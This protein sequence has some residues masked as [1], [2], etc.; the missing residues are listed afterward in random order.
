MAR[1]EAKQATKQLDKTTLMLSAWYANR[2]SDSVRVQNKR[3]SELNLASQALH[4]L[5]YEVQPEHVLQLTVGDEPAKGSRFTRLPYDFY[6][7][8]PVTLDPGEELIFE[9]ADYYT[10]RGGQELFVGDY[11]LWIAVSS[12]AEA[13]HEH[14]RLMIIEHQETGE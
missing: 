1:I 4:S 11:S 9:R 8:Y 6:N 7:E 13:L 3:A 2:E 10:Q 14:S 5:V 12:L